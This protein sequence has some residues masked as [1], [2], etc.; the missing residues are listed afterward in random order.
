MRRTT[1]RLAAAPPLVSLASLGL[2]LACVAATSPAR[3]GDKEQCAAASEDAQRLQKQGKLV[4]AQKQLLVCT[5]AVC[6]AVVRQDCE[7]WLPALEAMI[8]SLVVAVRDEDGKDLVDVK[9]TLDG[10]VVDAASGRAVMLD[11]GKH[12]L[13]VESPGK[14]PS[15]QPV[16]VRDGERA[17]PVTV[18]LLAK[19]RPAKPVVT[20]PPPQVVVMRSP[21]APETSPFVWVLGTLATVSLASFV[22]FEVK[23]STDA[24]HLRSTCAPRCPQSEVDSVST[25]G[26]VAN[27]SLALA[28]GFAGGAFAVWLLGRPSTPSSASAGLVVGPGRLGL[29]GRF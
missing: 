13:H 23:A 10:A 22:V 27:V 9:I 11:P 3:A 14:I 7:A 4:D 1:S 8:P 18:T 17:R 20:P 21:P 5:R 19:D 15:D 29:Q 12:T 6:P 26:V 28:G 24:S 2:V 16:V 25:Q